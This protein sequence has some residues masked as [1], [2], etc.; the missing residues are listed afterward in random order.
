MNSDIFQAI[1]QLLKLIR[2]PNLLIIFLS[3]YLLR[4]FIVLP[5]FEIA[6][7]EST[8]SEFYFF[9]LALAVVLISGGAYIQND[10]LDIENDDLN[11]R[12]KMLLNRISEKELDTLFKLFY[13]IG[14]VLGFYIALKAGR[15]QLGFI[16]V[17]ATLL[18]ILYNRLFKRQMLVG[19]VLVALLSAFVL[20]LVLLFETPVLEVEA[21]G[22]NRL[23]TLLYVQVMAYA[24]YAFFI[25]LARE[26]V[27]DLEDEKGD[28]ALRMQ[29]L[30]VV[31]GQKWTKA[32]V[33]F[34]LIIVIAATGYIA[35][36]YYN[37][38][39]LTHFSYIGAAVILP[40]LI[41]AWRLI[42]AQKASGFR[43]VST[44]LKFVMLTGIL[45]MPVFYYLL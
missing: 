5:I 17:F 3:M 38:D 42:K 16:F 33:L 31:L 4:H 39:Q 37:A 6:E 40:L 10:L 18:L 36:M 11:G 15:F 29:T 1:K 44:L 8:L 2:W 28:E 45:S 30:A 34:L 9:Q 20:L 32:I 35:M 27:K 25:S 19:N 43:Q 12:N 14:N 21:V 26:I 41:T 23:L 13:G 7:I 24:I 22:L